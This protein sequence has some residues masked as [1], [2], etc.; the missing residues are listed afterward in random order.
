[1]FLVKI[2]LY[3][4]LNLDLILITSSPYNKEITF[5]AKKLDNVM[6]L[7]DQELSA[8]KTFVY[9]SPPSYCLEGLLNWTCTTCGEQTTNTSHVKAFGDFKYIFGYTAVNTNLQL[10][11]ISFRG[12]RN[13]KSWMGNIKF[14]QLDYPYEG[15]PEGAKVHGGF[16]HEYNSVKEEVIA[17][18][19]ELTSMYPNFQ[20]LFVGHS[21]GGALSVLSLIDLK[22]K[23]P[24]MEMKKINLITIAQPRIGNYIFSKWINEQFSNLNNYFRIV[25]KNDA[26]PHLPPSLFGFKHSGVEIWINLVNESYYCIPDD[27]MLE[28]KLCSNTQHGLS[29]ATHK[30][31]WDIDIGNS[32]CSIDDDIYYHNLDEIL[33]D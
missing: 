23:Y 26:T 18:I 24:E 29:V 4:L 25:N 22:L 19:L 5:L 32:R 8:V 9:F 2:V 21:L 11:I 17:N 3:F 28:S 1:M 7:S 20:I 15:A 13:F 31:C 14:A 16:L 10:I 33:I 27:D 6:R 30:H 12:T